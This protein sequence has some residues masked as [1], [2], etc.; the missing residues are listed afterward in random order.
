ME[1]CVERRR[2]EAGA[3]ADGRGAERAH[4]SIPLTIIPIEKK[5]SLQGAK[6]RRIIEEYDQGEIERLDWLDRL[7]VPIL[8]QRALD[9]SGSEF[10]SGLR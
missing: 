3:G 8:K 1:G 6:Y 9:R 10:A 2:A 4:R 7:S 5:K